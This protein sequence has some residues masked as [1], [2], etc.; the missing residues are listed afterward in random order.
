MME[1][2][3]DLSIVLF[4]DK[5]KIV[6]SEKVTLEYNPYCAHSKAVKLSRR[7]GTLSLLFDP[8]IYAI[9]AKSKKMLFSE[10]EVNYSEEGLLSWLESLTEH[11]RMNIQSL[12]FGKESVFNTTKVQMTCT[13]ERMKNDF[14][15][16]IKILP[17][18][19]K[20]TSY[21]KQLDF[22]EFCDVLELVIAAQEV[23]RIQ[24]WA[25]KVK[26]LQVLY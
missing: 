12:T 21:F 8:K 19:E 1:L 13:S 17:K 15:D 23:R 2:E 6:A 24:K 16:I 10:V 26:Q 11:Q 4:R 7:I 5:S 18:V 25:C 14:C 20:I 9:I 3:Y 22:V